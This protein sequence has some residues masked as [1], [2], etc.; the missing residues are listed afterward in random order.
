MMLMWATIGGTVFDPAKSKVADTIDVA[1]PMGG[2]PVRG[3]FGTGI[4]KNTQNKDAAWAVLT[5]LTSKE[6]EKYQVGT[7]KTDPSRLSTYNDPDLGLVGAVPADLGRGVRDG[8]D[9]A[10]GPGAGDVRDHD[11]VRR[12]VRHRADGRRRRG[13]RLRQGAGPHRR[14]PPARRLAGLSAGSSTH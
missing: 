12:G 9:P 7:Y 8:D 14:D 5:Y 1:V 2:K 13:G 6:W 11:R 10:A 3:G 4:P